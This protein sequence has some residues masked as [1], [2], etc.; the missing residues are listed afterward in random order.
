MGLAMVRA[1]TQLHGDRGGAT[2]EGSGESACFMVRL[3]A[4]QPVLG[5]VSGRLE[6]ALERYDR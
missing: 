6:V 5:D 4:V 3:P 2:T 1:P